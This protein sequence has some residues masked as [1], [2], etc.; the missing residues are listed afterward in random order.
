[1]EIPES[2]CFSFSVFCLPVFSN[3]TASPVR[4]FVV[5]FSLL[6]GTSTRTL[7]LLVLVAL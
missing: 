4:V 5:V 3:L 1:M 6:H 7:D 2:C